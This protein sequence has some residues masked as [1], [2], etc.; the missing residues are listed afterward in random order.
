MKT[1]FYKI[2][3]ILLVL[4]MSSTAF[5]QKKVLYVG[6][7]DMPACD[8]AITTALEDKEYEVTWITKATYNTDFPDAAAYSDYDVIMLSESLS[9]GDVKPFKAAGF[10]IPCVNLEGFSV[11]MDRWDFMPTDMEATDFLQGGD[12][13]ADDGVLTLIIEDA[14]HWIANQYEP[15]YE[16]VWSTSLLTDGVTGFKLD[17]Y[18]DG[19]IQIGYYNVADFADLPSIWVIPEGSVILS[20]NSVIASN[21]VLIGSIMDG[22]SEPTEEFIDFLVI[23]IRWATDDIPSSVSDMQSN[24]L[25]IYPNPTNGIVNVSLTLPVSENVRVNIYDIAGKLMKTID[26]DDLSAGYHTI[27]F[28]ISGLAE[29]QYIYEIT[30]KNDILRGKICKTK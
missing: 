22:M 7:N 27:S 19:A 15:D 14:D 1:N 29:A 2:T 28:D 4:F 13:A 26:S 24:N 11:K 12:A 25:S 6:N 21:V 5:A 20:D 3:L 23:C 9:S 30:T 18:V 8:S 16:L 10:P 17:P